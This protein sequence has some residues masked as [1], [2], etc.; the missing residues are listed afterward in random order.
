[1]Y[2]VKGLTLN[3]YQVDIEPYEESKALKRKIWCSIEN[4]VMD[5]LGLTVFKQTFCL[6]IL[7]F[8]EGMEF[9]TNVGGK[10]YTIRVGYV[11]V[12]RPWENEFC[13]YLDE[14]IRA[15]LKSQ[16]Y[17][18]F[19]KRTFLDT[20]NLTKVDDI[21]YCS[22]LKYYLQQHQNEYLL[23]MNPYHL[24]L[25]DFTILH[26][27]NSIKANNE[28][29]DKDWKKEILSALV[30]R[31]IY[32]IYNKM[33]YKIT[34]VAFELSPQD[35]FYAKQKELTYME[36]YNSKTLIITD[37][38]QPLLAVSQRNNTIYLVPEFCCLAGVPDKL[39]NDKKL[40]K[41]VSEHINP[42]PD[43]LRKKGIELM[44]TIINN[45]KTIKIANDYGMTI[46]SSPVRVMGTDLRSPMIELG[47]GI[48]QANLLGN[49]RHLLT[50]LRIPNLSIFG[51]YEDKILVIDFVH[52]LHNAYS[53]MNVSVPITN[54]Y[55]KKDEKWGSFILNN[56][57]ANAFALI[58]L[59]ERNT[60][61]EIKKTLATLKIPS[62]II[63]TQTIR[64]V[65]D[66]VFQNK[67]GH[68]LSNLII[69]IGCKL[70]HPCFRV[71]NLPFY[72]LQPL[73][74]GIYHLRKGQRNYLGI[75][76]NKNA[77][78]NIYKYR[79]IECKDGEIIQSVINVIFF[80]YSIFFKKFRMKIKKLWFLFRQTQ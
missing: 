63:M 71:N 19:T 43:I 45:D 14:F 80:E 34:D 36:Y 2:S 47:N 77:D 51:T 53:R 78:H 31:S 55:Y 29:S 72:N 8:S 7:F 35:S 46:D 73:S 74:F 68:V 28:G 50:L 59:P 18:C 37:P 67:L 11:S 70:D 20:K 32:T 25:S 79:F 1:M 40:M 38:S 16:S 41:S 30:G 58:L 17:S 6:S 75:T 57:K 64:S 56:I 27:I 54:Y 49:S 44:N 65:E 4:S 15:V 3:K 26:L 24:V 23:T 22:G 5:K 48:F 62:Q 61:K 66:N 10:E 76:V 42:N 33:L 21:V 60:Y 9:A 13:L 69:N 39:Q 12:V 52:K